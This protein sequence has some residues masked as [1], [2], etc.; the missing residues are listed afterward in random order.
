MGVILKMH[1][2]PQ[3]HKACLPSV[4]TYLY[5]LLDAYTWSLTSFYVIFAKML[6]LLL[7]VTKKIKTEK[8]KTLILDW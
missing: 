5:I 8:Q 3:S 6:L 7:S 2:R 1:G 4:R